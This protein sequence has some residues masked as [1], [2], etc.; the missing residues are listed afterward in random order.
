M[1]GFD[2]M[3]I[4]GKI[5]KAN[6]DKR[7]VFGWASVAVD[8]DGV[9]V[10]DSDG[11]VI[12]IEELERGA[13]EFVEF[14]REGGAMHERRGVAQLVESCVF[15]AEKLSAMGL[16]A[17]ALPLGWWIGFRVFDDAVW[18]KVKS[19]EYNMFSIGGR[20]DRKEI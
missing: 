19:G 16:S 10:V 6:F 11:D 1:K 5:A 20:A 4:T 9:A 14:Y 8:R 2:S 3:K 17:D 18:Q 13:Y 7:L 12:R 15:T